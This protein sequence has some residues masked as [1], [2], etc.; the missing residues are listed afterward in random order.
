MVPN[1][2]GL[3]G[4]KP[5]RPGQDDSTQ[6]RVALRV[7]QTVDVDGHPG[8]L[9]QAAGYPDGGVHGGHIAAIW[10]QGRAGY[11]LSLHFTEQRHAP[12]ISW[13]RT[14]SSVAAAMSRSSGRTHSRVTGTASDP[15]R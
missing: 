15:S 9:L 2:L 14:V 4:A 13:Q 1:D 10:N 5:L 12:N 6:T 7:L 11:V 3:I 8:L